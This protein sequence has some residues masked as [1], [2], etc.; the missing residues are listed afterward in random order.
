LPRTGGRR[1]VE[2]GPRHD[3]DPALPRLAVALCKRFDHRNLAGDIE[4]VNTGAQTGG[5]HRRRS[6]RERSGSVQNDAHIR[7]GRVELGGVGEAGGAPRQSERF[8]DGGELGG[9]A[10]AEDRPQ[11]ERQRRL[12]NQPS[13]EAGGAIEQERIGHQNQRGDAE[14]RSNAK[15]PSSF[16]SSD[17]RV[18]VSPFRKFPGP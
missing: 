3:H 2:A 10:A 4:I 18:S 11:A 1:D 6:L 17:L 14:A 13:G 12:E 9:I 15:K 7:Q 16:P 5:H 8:G